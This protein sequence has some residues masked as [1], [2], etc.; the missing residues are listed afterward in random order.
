MICQLPDSVRLTHLGV[1]AAFPT[2]NVAAECPHRS[3]N[4]KRREECLNEHLLVSMQHAGEM[5]NA[6]RQEYR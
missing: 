2:I 6:R 3:V 1:L 4:G 5:I